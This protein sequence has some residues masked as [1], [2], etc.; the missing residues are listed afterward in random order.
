MAIQV[1]TYMMFCGPDGGMGCFSLLGRETVRQ[2][3]VQFVQKHLLGLCHDDW[4]HNADCMQQS[5]VLCSHFR[6]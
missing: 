5:I 1:R 6:N 3:N 2:R 4:V